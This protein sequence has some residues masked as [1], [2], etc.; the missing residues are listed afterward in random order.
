MGVRAVFRHLI[1]DAYRIGSPQP[2]HG[3]AVI[4]TVN[5]TTPLA[6]RGSK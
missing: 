6:C 4:G 5:S 1:D 3:D 2:P